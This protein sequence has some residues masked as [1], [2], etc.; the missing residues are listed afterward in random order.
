[1]S[2]LNTIESMNS[3]N[4]LSM[5]NIVNYIPLDQPE[6][7]TFTKEMFDRLVEEV[8]NELNDREYDVNK[9]AVQKLVR[10]WYIAKEPLLRLFSKHPNWNPEKYRIE[11]DADYT[12]EILR[13][14]I[15]DF[16]DWLYRPATAFFQEKA[17]KM[18]DAGEIE[19]DSLQ[20]RMLRADDIFNDELK[21]FI[22]NLKTQYLDESYKDRLD[23]L[24]AYNDKFSLR[25][26]GKASKAVLKICRVLGWDK[27]FANPNNIRD[28]FNHRF[29]AFSDCINPI[30]VKRHTVLGLHLLDFLLMSYG[31]S[32]HSCHYIGQY[33]EDA[34]CYSSGT[35]S[36]ALDECSFIFYT[37]DASYE[38]NELELQPKM[39]RQVYGYRDE[40]LFQSRMYP[41]SM[42]YGA[43]EAYTDTRNIVQ[44][45]IADCL[46]KPNLW[47]LK[48]T[49]EAVNEV[50][51]HGMNATCYPD[52]HRGNPGSTHCT[53]STLK[54]RPERISEIIMGAEPICP[55]CGERHGNEE[56]IL[57]DDCNGSGYE[58]ADCGCRMSE[59]DARYVEEMGDYY[60]EDCSFWC[61]QTQAYHR[62]RDAV[63]YHHI[64]YMGREYTEDV[65]D[66]WARDYACW[67]ENRDEYWD[68]DDVVC[69][70]GRSYY[71][72]EYRVSN[73]EGDTFYRCDGTHEYYDESEIVTVEDHWG[74]EKHYSAEYFEDHEEEI[75]AE[76]HRVA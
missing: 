2:N 49:I 60:C 33:P 25:T 38:G 50:V 73:E 43:D 40:Q 62:N 42:D 37:V 46:E 19:W 21:S 52:W 27:A 58:C 13:D 53:I 70:S 66:E 67:V 47:T 29:A 45:V 22:W 34:G 57:C 5:Q 28:D 69:L 35:L 7:Y 54:G 10:A 41:Q 74:N 75:L 72:G 11:F 36:Y 1:M 16:A 18:V 39:T 15:Q 14:G 61:E 63:E 8:M 4:A 31:N 24:N 30:K 6:Q 23:S 44:K 68:P 55:R 20:Y 48:K 56:N 65:Y 32:W 71:E 17:R 9:Y 64:G 76:Y 59:D 26:N 12:R 3:V 51:K